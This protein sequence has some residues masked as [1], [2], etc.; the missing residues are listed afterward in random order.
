MSK[1]QSS[2]TDIAK[3]WG[4][5]FRMQCGAR[6]AFD[7]TQRLGTPEPAR[8]IPNERVAATLKDGESV[9]RLVWRCLELRSRSAWGAR[10]NMILNFRVGESKERSGTASVI[11]GIRYDD[12]A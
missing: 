10:N 2:H 3:D 11:S 1:G 9:L 8:R 7:V 4:C 6:G 12:Y 5:H